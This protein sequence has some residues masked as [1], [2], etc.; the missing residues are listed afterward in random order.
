MT[1]FEMFMVWLERKDM[2]QE[3]MRACRSCEVYQREL[4]K[5]HGSHERLMNELV[6]LKNPKVERAPD[7]IPTEMKQ[8][9]SPVA[10]WDRTRMKLEADDARKAE[11]QA[12]EEALRKV[13]EADLTA[14]RNANLEKEVGVSDA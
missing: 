1:F 13:R 5:L 11:L 14:R 12:K 4:D 3:R 2:R 6:Y 9:L 8:V 10:N 7:M